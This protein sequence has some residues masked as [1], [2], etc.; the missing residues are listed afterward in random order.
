MMQLN[1]GKRTFRV[2]RRLERRRMI[3][4]EATAGNRELRK[5]SGIDGI[6]HLGRHSSHPIELPRVQLVVLVSNVLGL[7]MVLQLEAGVLSFMTPGLNR[8]A[9]T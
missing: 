9:L 6:L 1:V 2:G 4:E 5:A 8:N 3:G 7:L